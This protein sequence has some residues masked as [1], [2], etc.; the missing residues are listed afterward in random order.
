MAVDLTIFQQRG[1]FNE[2]HTSI[3]LMNRMKE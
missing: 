3:D 1:L 2:Y